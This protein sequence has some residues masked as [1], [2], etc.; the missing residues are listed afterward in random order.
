MGFLD[1][2]QSTLQRGADSASR[3]LE[4]SSING[5]IKDAEK[6]RLSFAATSSDG[7]ECPFC[8]NA[9]GATDKFCS[10]C[11]KP[12]AEVQAYYAE[13]ASQE[14]PSQAAP[15]CPGCGAPVN[16]GDKFCM[17]CGSSLA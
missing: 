11:G 17:N 9:M 3:S 15:V 1:D 12:M 16:E 14:E 4:I 2:M 8:H 13:H 5:Q 7:V 6:R 10:G